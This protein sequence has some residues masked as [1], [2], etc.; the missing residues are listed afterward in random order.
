MFQNVQ[1]HV[2]LTKELKPTC[3]NFQKKTPKDSHPQAATKVQ[4]LI[5]TQHIAKKVHTLQ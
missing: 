3:Y 1:F 4:Q 2:F 5:I